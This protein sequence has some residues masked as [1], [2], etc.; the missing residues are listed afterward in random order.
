MSPTPTTLPGA[1]EQRQITITANHPLVSSSGRLRSAQPSAATATTT[2]TSGVSS[3]VQIGN[4][5]GGPAPTPTVTGITI[6]GPEGPYLVGGSYNFTASAEDDNDENLVIVHDAGVAAAYR[7]IF[8][9]LFAN[10]AE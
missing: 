5:G 6:N 10:H 8:D 4:G 7:T 9:D 1:S 3:P 2:G